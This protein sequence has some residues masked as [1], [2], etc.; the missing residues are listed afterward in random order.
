MWLG[1][2][3]VVCD[4]RP[5]RAG[6]ALLALCVG[7]RDSSIIVAGRGESD[8]IAGEKTRGEP[9]FELSTK[10]FCK[11]VI[12]KPDVGDGLIADMGL[13]VGEDS[14]KSVERFTR[15]KE[16]NLDASA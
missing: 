4:G 12:R 14:D 13:S 7:V 5:S 3:E 15:V 2:T 6:V 10:E 11:L 1:E 9:A 8:A 16:A